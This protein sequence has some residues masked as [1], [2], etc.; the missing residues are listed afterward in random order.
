MDD[1][2]DMCYEYQRCTSDKCTKHTLLDG[3][4]KEFAE[5]MRNGRL[6]GD[7]IYEEE[8]KVIENE[9]EDEKK[10][11]LHAKAVEE[12]KSLDSL[13][14]NIL[15]KN[16]VRNCVKHGNKYVLKH[17]FTKGCENLELPDEVLSDGSKYPGGCWA[18]QEG[19][20][21][22]M[23]PDE[24]DKYDFK[25]KTKLVLVE[26]ERNHTHTKRTGIP[27]RHSMTKKRG[28]RRCTRKGRKNRK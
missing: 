19:V 10:K 6:W 28:G 21:P 24:K 9:T 3:N 7:I 27:P 17:K 2:C 14:E 5:A 13:K 18:H 15:N 12:R 1:E 11:R 22:F 23:H 16:H 8:K 20:C 4:V 26:E 25:G